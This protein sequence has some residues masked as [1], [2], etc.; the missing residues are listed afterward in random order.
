MQRRQRGFTIVE[1]MIVVVIIAVL[2][3]VTLVVYNN[4][5]NQSADTKRQNDIILLRNA[6]KKYH[7][8]NG[9]YPKPDG[10]TEQPSLVE[11]WK[12][13][14]QTTLIASGYLDKP[15]QPDR[16]I[17]FMSGKNFAPNNTAYYLYYVPDPNIYA[18]YVPLSSGDCKTGV[19][20]NAVWWG[21]I[22]MCNF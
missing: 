17:T 4:V 10:C 12:N 19:N 15:V 22:K 16:P 1:I 8:E 9:E 11:C 14:L 2:A 7:D 18:L 6:L 13:Q 20:V 3:S 5:Q 21:G